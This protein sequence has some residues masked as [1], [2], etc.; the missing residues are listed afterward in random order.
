M[1]K[2]ENPASVSFP[3][4]FDREILSA[5]LNSQRPALSDSEVA[6]LRAFFELLDRWDRAAQTPEQEAG[7]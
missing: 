1:S 7:R 3:S 6:A 4:S 5:P 2:S